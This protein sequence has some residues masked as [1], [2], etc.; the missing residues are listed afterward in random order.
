[1]FLCYLPGVV[2]SPAMLSAS[3]TGGHLPIP[4]LFQRPASTSRVV[5]HGNVH[6]CLT[7]KVGKGYM[8]QPSV[9]FS[10]PFPLVRGRGRRTT[11]RDERNKIRRTGIHLLGNT[12]GYRKRCMSGRVGWR[13]EHA[14]WSES[15]GKDI[16]LRVVSMLSKL[17]AKFEAAADPR[18]LR[19]ER[20]PCSG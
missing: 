14:L 6:R 2:G 10:G 13:N 19:E 17:V 3:E 16:P 4:G 12:I 8:R 7:G 20:G 18:A 9:W 1:M 15:N 11:T 5:R